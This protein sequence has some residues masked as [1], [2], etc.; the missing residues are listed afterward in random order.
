MTH[1]QLRLAE[2]NALTTPWKKFGPYLTE[3]RA[4]V[5]ACRAGAAVRVSRAANKSAFIS[6]RRRNEESRRLRPDRWWGKGKAPGQEGG[7][8]KMMPV[9][10]QL[11]SATFQEAVIF[12][13]LPKN[14]VAAGPAGNL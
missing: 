9:F 2:A 4:A 8:V 12:P 5:W 13:E 6:R 1:E 14:Y 3:R 11:L 10:R 7:V